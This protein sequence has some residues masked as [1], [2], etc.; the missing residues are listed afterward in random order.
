MHADEVPMD[1]GTARR[2]I[3]A[4]FPEWR[5]KPVRRL[6]TAGTVN[7]IVRIG[8]DLTAKFP[9][10][11]C[12]PG[13]VRAQLLHEIEAM[14]ELAVCCPFPVPLAVAIGE[15][16]DGY[17]LP[18]SVQTWLHGEVASPHSHES[19][20]AFARDLV[21]LIQS[22]RSADTRGRSFEGPGRGGDLTDSDEW[23]NVCL[24]E[25]LGLLPVD[26]L[27]QAWS[28]LRTLPAPG[29]DVMSHRDLIPGNVLVEGEHIIGI[30][31]G[32]GFGPADPALDLVA[33]WHLLDTD[34]RALLRAALSCGDLEWYRGAAWAFQQA[35]GL[36]WYYR[37]SNP[38][39]SALGRTTL[40]RILDDPELSELIEA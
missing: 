5:Q 33:G 14:R 24:R 32:G 28:R 1:E 19:S 23:M 35:M 37:E 18:W 10:R 7:A 8:D 31:D 4:Q 6:A 2:L 15:P 16:G 22:L 17:P 30:L 34:R 40:T 12:E 36:V 39:M 11:R 3:D 27:R 13:S 21:M 38:V 9:L 25:S 29:P 20:A 26:R